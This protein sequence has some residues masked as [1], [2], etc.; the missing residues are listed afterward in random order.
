MDKSIVNDLAFASTWKDIMVIVAS[1]DMIEKIEV[2][3]YFTTHMA[4]E[5]ETGCFASHNAIYSM[6]AAIRYVATGEER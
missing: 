2:L 6:R 1:M 4:C 5:Q 3:S